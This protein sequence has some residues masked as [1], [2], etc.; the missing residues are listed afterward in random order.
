MGAGMGQT[1]ANEALHA[2]AMQ[3]IIAYTAPVVP[4]LLLPGMGLWLG[5][6][7]HVS[8]Q[9]NLAPN[10]TNRLDLRTFRT[11]PVG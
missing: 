4:N 8:K 1:M 3:D 2:F 6:S 9:P 7:S 5:V 11:K 10:E